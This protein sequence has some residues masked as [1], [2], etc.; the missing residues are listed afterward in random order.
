MKWKNGR[1]LLVKK[2]PKAEKRF[3]CAEDREEYRVL[4]KVENF[5]NIVK[6]QTVLETDTDIYLVFRYFGNDKLTNYL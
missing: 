4:D 6:L 1:Q 3:T 5:E 2:F